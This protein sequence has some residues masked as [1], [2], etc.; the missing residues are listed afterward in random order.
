[1]P[2]P[3]PADSSYESGGGR[4]ESSGV[5]CHALRG[6]QKADN[7]LQLS[8]PHADDRRRA[9]VGKSLP[10]KDA[11]VDRSRIVHVSHQDMEMHYRLRNPSLDRG[12]PPEV[13]ILMPLNPRKLELGPQE[14]FQ[15]FQQNAS[16]SLAVFGHDSME[17]GNALVRIAL[18][19]NTESA[20]AMIQS[21]LALSSLH[22]HGLSNQAAELKISALNK[23]GAASSSSLSKAEAMQ[24]V[25]TNMLLCSYEIHL[26]SCTS[27][28][29]TCYVR[30]AMAIIRV[31]GLDGYHQSRDMAMLQDWVY[32]HDVLARFSLRHWWRSGLP[33]SLNHSVLTPPPPTIRAEPSHTALPAIGLIELLSEV[34]DACPVGLPAMTPTGSGSDHKNFL[35]ILDWKIRTMKIQ[36]SPENDVDEPLMM[37]LYRLALLVY[38]S[39]ASKDLLKQRFRTQQYI[40]KAFSIFPQLGSCN[41]QFP[42]FILGSEARTDDQRAVVLDL[43]TRA[44]KRDSSRLFHHS[45][46][47]LQAIWAQNDLSDGELDYCTGMSHVISLCVIAPSFA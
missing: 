22:G 37:E 12:N 31:A 42:V 19:D 41:R 44:E 24:H 47:L 39:R 14:L 6:L 30:S 4:G 33:S 20:K 10:R 3:T 26:S 32:Y 8:W 18:A 38:L 46:I 9:V 35:S 43:M 23:L 15:Y 17:L 11:H 27:G 25:A 16:K 7:G 5:V 1:M 34:C 36:V 28:E 40:E 13:D 45:R 2:S 29:W 21:M